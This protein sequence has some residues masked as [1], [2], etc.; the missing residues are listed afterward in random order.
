MPERPERK[1]ELSER[2]IKERRERGRPRKGTG[3]YDIHF[4]IRLSDKEIDI[5][6]RIGKGKPRGEVVR[7][8]INVMGKKMEA[9]GKI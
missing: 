4:T 8:M 7:D 6:D 5:I 3:L 1:R 9:A 2:E